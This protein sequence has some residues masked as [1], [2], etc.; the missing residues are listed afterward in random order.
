MQRYSIDYLSG[1]S[2]MWHP[3]PVNMAQVSELIIVNWIG[4][5]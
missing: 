4:V 1:S 5:N 2:L 3:E